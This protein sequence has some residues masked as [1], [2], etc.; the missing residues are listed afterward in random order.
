MFKQL[1]LAAFA[2]AALATAAST[3]NAIQCPPWTCTSNGTQL[4]GI[5]LGRLEA[6]AS[7]PP[8]ACMTN[9][10]QPRG[11]RLGTASARPVGAVVL[12]SGETVDLR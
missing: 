8:Y 4:T 9:G 7:C 3:A 10:T 6:T 5:A 2:A 11:L 1:S 12:P